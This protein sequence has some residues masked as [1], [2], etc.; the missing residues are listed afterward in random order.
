MQTFAL[1]YIN[2]KHAE[3]TVFEKV[4]QMFMPPTMI[5]FKKMFFCIFQK[6]F[7]EKRITLTIE[8]PI[9]LVHRMF[10]NRA[11]YNYTLSA[12]RRSK[13]Q[14]QKL[15]TTTSTCCRVYDFAIIIVSSTHCYKI[16]FPVE[17]Q[18]TP[19]RN[20]NPSWSCGCRKILP[21][22]PNAKWT[23]PASMV[24]LTV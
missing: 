17:K 19:T 11:N 12:Q 22:N 15:S 21:N 24:N 7:I 14:Q 5:R 8:H 20:E 2:S 10:V 3:F 16:S 23:A 4:S 1:I 6:Y 9:H 18:T 13:Q